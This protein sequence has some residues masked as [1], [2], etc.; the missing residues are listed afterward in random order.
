M[1]EAFLEIEVLENNCRREKQILKLAKAGYA[2]H[3]QAQAAQFISNPKQRN[4]KTRTY[5][6]HAEMECNLEY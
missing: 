2:I 5:R 6:W 1:S 3:F 4:I